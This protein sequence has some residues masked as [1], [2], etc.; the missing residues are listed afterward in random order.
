MNSCYVYLHIRLD[1]S[2]VFYVGIGNDKIS[3]TKFERAY[4]KHKR[5]R[6]WQAIIKKTGYLV[7][8]YKENLTWEEACYFE[9][10]LIALYGRRDLNTGP[11]TNLTN[12][13]EG[14][15]GLKMTVESREKMRQRK[16]GKKQTPEQ[17]EKTKIALSNRVISDE[18]KA[19]IALSKIGNKNGVGKRSEDFGQKIRNKKIG[20]ARPL[21]VRINISKAKKGISHNGKGKIIAFKKDGTFSGEFKH[22]YE[23]AKQLGCSQQLISKVLTGERKST[24]GFLF[25]RL[26][27][28]VSN[29]K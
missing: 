13:G 24:N 6:F 19:K 11:L 12:G 28:A 25:K 22:T 7:E 10:Q 14:A 3:K 4:S 15:N 18:T 27:H 16:I 29:S 26:G 2:E 8:I 23:A 1:K 17:I 21:E 5:N 9:T 20:I